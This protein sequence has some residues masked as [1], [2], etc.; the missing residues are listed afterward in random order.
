MAGQYRYQLQPVQTSR[1]MYCQTL[2]DDPEILRAEAR[3]LL[4]GLRRTLNA[5]ALGG[6]AM[7]DFET[8]EYTPAGN[9]LIGLAG[10]LTP[11]RAKEHATVSA[12][13]V[14]SEVNDITSWNTL[15]N[16]IIAGTEAWSE[17]WKDPSAIREPGILLVDGLQ[18]IRATPELPP[19]CVV[20][21][22]FAMYHWLAVSREM[23][24]LLK[25]RD[26]EATLTAQI[27]AAAC[28]ADPNAF[29]VITNP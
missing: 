1:P 14:A 7:M 16:L 3:L 9:D 28:I 29:V 11:G 19:P 26:Q 6:K 21:G 23:R 8:K 4:R 24:V 20:A 13:I 5:Q 22:D 10:A 15:P 2:E 25:V 27:Q 12:N 17:L 18:A